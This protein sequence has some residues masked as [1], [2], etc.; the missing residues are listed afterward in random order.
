MRFNGKVERFFRTLKLWQRMTLILCTETGIQK[1][2]ERFR[3]Y[4]NAERVHQGIVGMTPNE[5]W[6][7]MVRPERRKYLA[8]DPEPV[9]L[10]VIRKNYEGDL[11]LPT[12]SIAPI[13]R[14]A[15]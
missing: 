9:E 5:K 8:R 3:G 15:A 14:R 1:H 10:R 2:L 6:E 12:A 7:A 11:F 13:G 4:Y